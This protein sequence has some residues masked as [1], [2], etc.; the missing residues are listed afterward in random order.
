MTLINQFQE[1]VLEEQKA[2][3]AGDFERSP[4]YNDIQEMKYLEMFIKEGQ[5]I[6]PSVPF[7]GREPTEYLKLSGKTIPPGTTL[8]LFIMATGYNE[9]VFP[10]PFKFDPERFSSENLSKRSSPY[11]YVPFSAGPRNCIGQK[12]AMLELKTVLSKIVRYFEVLPAKDELTSKD[13]YER[14]E[15]SEY[16][17]KLSA[18]LTLK[19]DNGI[20]IRL[21]ARNL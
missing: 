2:I 5:R 4:T 11:E 16:D 18:V 21:R 17:P 7:I 10:D 13:G 1:K 9:N 14:W 8:N 12:F 6:Y 15:Q 19:S 3:F 20:L